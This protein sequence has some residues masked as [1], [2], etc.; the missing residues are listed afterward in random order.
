MKT[1]TNHRKDVE[2]MKKKLIVSV[3][4]FIMTVTLAIGV[5]AIYAGSRYFDDAMDD[6]AYDN[7][8]AVY[9]DG[10]IT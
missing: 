9:E 5:N 4:A 6:M 8:D 2:F 7:I 10:Y 3:T 1:K